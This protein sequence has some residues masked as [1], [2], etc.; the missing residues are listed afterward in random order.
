MIITDVNVL[1]AAYRP[2]LLVHDACS[3]W[4]RRTLGS[5]EAFGVSEFVLSSFL[6]IVTNPRIFE[7]P[8][9]FEQALAFANILR[10]RPNAVPVTPGERH[11]SVFSRLCQSVDAKGDTV[12]DA[13]LAALAIEWGAE[14]ITLDRG[15]ARFPDLRW[16]HP[17]A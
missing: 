2:E 14:W 4:L 1:V 12:P 15:F 8:A 13:Y 3:D 7:S 17:L 11:W 5:D 10:T 16:S 9:P 6:R